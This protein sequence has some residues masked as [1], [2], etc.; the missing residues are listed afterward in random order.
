MTEQLRPCID[1]YCGA[2]ITFD[3][4]PAGVAEG[5]P[6]VQAV[7]EALRSVTRADGLLDGVLNPDK[8]A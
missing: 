7:Y 8:D 3:R 2:R 6:L 1:L 4:L 5:D